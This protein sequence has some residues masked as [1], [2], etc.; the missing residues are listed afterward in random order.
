MRA[1]LHRPGEDLHK[2]DEPSLQEAINLKL[3]ESGE[4]EKLKDLLRER[5]I[6]CGWKDELKA[7]C[8]A[9]TRKRG[10]SNVTIDEL[11]RAITPKGRALVPDDVKAELLQRIRTFL[12][13]V[14][15]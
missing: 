11:V 10:R 9:F 7:Q 1:S 4:K 14:Q 6:E 8:R 13:S 3:V 15:F 5:L 2:R 12:L